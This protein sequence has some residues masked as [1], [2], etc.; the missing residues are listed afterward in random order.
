MWQ[1]AS[2]SSGGIELPRAQRELDG[3]EAGLGADERAGVAIVRRALEAPLRQIADAGSLDP[4][5]L[6]G[7][8][9]C[10]FTATIDLH[11]TWIRLIPKQTSHTP[12]T[13]MH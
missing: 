12:A 4:E 2:D 11:S 3:L 6:P 1:N 9:G 10:E 7:V 13:T 8:P 5:C